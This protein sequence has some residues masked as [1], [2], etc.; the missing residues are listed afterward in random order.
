MK[1]HIEISRSQTILKLL[2]K[3]GQMTQQ[4]LA[5][6]LGISVSEVNDDLEALYMVEPIVASA[7]PYD[8]Q[9]PQGGYDEDRDDPEADYLR[10]DGDGVVRLVHALA[11]G[12]VSMSLAELLN[13]L[14]A[15]DALSAAADSRTL[16][17]LSEL[18]GRLVDAA[19]SKGFA[20]ALWV[21]PGPA[22]PEDVRNAIANAIVT[23]RWIR[24][25]YW[26]TGEDGLARAED[27]KVAPVVVDPRK[28]PLLVAANEAKELRH[29]RLDRISAVEVLDAPVRKGL[30]KDILLAARRD[31]SFTGTKARIVVTSAARW[32]AETILNDG[33]AISDGQIAIDLHVRSANWL[34]TLLI[35]VGRE[36]VSVEPP[37]LAADVAAAA[38]RILE[39][40]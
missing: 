2:E 21:A 40:S 7:P 13:L 1:G 12:D 3:R 37:E 24:I 19:G 22:A 4:Q 39:A 15:I 29:Y 30:K 10:S 17:M 9:F 6:V 23:S 38:R 8:I 14:A 34:A 11:K 31:D 16:E 35:K 25:T 33:Y 18:R 32:V 28:N 36:V 26:K 27:A 20:D 5:D